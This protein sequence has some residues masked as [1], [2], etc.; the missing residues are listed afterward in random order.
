MSPPSAPPA[1][2]RAPLR[3]L[4]RVQ[5]LALRRDR[6]ALLLTFVLPV[7]VFS[8]FAIVFSGQGGGATSR[9]RLAVVDADASVASRRLVDALAQ[10]AGLRVQREANGVLLDRAHATA[11]V[12]EGKVPVALILPPG[13]GKALGTFAPTAPAA[14]LLTDEADPVAPQVVSGLLQKAA[15]TAMPDLLAERGLA[16]FE[17]WGG[18]LTAQQRA[19][20]DIWLPRLRQQGEGGGGGGTSASAS[21]AGMI[22]VQVSPLHRGDPDR[23]PAIAFYA[24]GTGVM[25]LLFAMAGAAGTLLEERESGTLERLLTCRLRLRDLLLGKWAFAAVMGAAQVTVMFV[26]GWLVFGLDLW[27]PQHLAGFAVMTLCTAAAAAAFGMLLAAISRSRAQLA[28]M[29]TIVILVMSALGGSMFPRF[30]MS[31]TMQRFGLITFNAWALDGYQKVFWYDR[32]VTA[33]WPQVGVLLAL[34]AVLLLG[35]GLALRRLVAR[36]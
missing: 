31:E 28:G 23:T 5:W 32:P 17:Q 21:A 10:D 35:A 7:V 26:W 19:A 33:L 29:S 27:T 14:Q 34:T 9:V 12:R 8:M 18:A 22:P 11:L 3:T 6:T 13:F 25:F 4:L 1:K 15:M 24:A 30:L 36:I 2:P 20:L 16:M